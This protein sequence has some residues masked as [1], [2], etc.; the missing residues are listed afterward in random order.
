M[1]FSKY[2]KSLIIFIFSIIIVFVIL[3]LAL[4]TV[5]GFLLLFPISLAVDSSI[6]N[7]LTAF[8]AIIFGYFFGYILGPL[9]IFVHKKTIGRKMIYE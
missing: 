5:P 1:A 4:P 9:F 3:F 8:I 6:I 7:L 2:L